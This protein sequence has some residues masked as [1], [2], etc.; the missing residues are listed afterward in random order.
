MKYGVQQYLLKPCNRRQIMEAIQS[1]KNSRQDQERL[2]SLQTENLYLKRRFHDTVQN[3]FLL[4]IF[5]GSQD[6][7]SIIQSYEP[8]LAPNKGSF[9]VLYTTYLEERYWGFCG[10][11]L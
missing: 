10:P 1:V 5:S 4:E 3:Q 7:A 9:S 8:L 11:N 6:S 2:V